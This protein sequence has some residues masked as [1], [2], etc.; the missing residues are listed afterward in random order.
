M[1][2]RKELERLALA[3][4]AT[5]M[6]T[7]MLFRIAS[8]QKFAEKR[9]SAFRII[10]SFTTV[11]TAKSVPRAAGLGVGIDGYLFGECQ[12]VAQLHFEKET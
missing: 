9:F 12:S 3:C 6:T 5:E 10:R 7:Q 11:Q 1:L 8:K 4:G 2:P